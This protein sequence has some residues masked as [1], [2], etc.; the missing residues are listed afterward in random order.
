ML[1][2]AG[3]GLTEVSASG[4]AGGVGGEFSRC[5]VPVRV[6]NP[7]FWVLREE[8]AFFT[9]NSRLAVSRDRS[10]LPE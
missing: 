9:L 2:R 3:V 6:L 4:G 8:A 1:L 7:G 5:V 10:S